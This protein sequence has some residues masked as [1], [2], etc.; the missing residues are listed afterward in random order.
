MELTTYSPDAEAE[1]SRVPVTGFRS[2]QIA[3]VAIGIA[4]IIGNGLTLYILSK[5]RKIASSVGGMLVVNQTVVDFWCS[6]VLV[7]T[8]SYKMHPLQLYQKGLHDLLCFFIHG[9][10]LFYSFVIAS[11]Y[12]LI[13]I[14]LERYLMVLHPNV[15]Q[16]SFTKSKAGILVILSWVLGSLHPIFAN[17]FS[18]FIDVNGRCRIQTWR[19]KVSREISAIVYIMHTYILPMLLF[20]FAYGRICWAL[21]RRKFQVVSIVKISHL[22]SVS[23]TVSHVDVIQP[24]RKLTRAQVNFTKTA[25]TIVLAFAAL[26][27]P[28]EIEVIRI[29]DFVISH[30]ASLFNAI[31]LHGRTVAFHFRS[32]CG[33]CNGS[34]DFLVL[35]FLFRCGKHLD[36]SSYFLHYF[37]RLNPL[38][39]NFAIRR[40]ARNSMIRIRLPGIWAFSRSSG[41]GKKSSNVP[42]FAAGNFGKK[43]LCVEDLTQH[44]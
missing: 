27:M 35:H 41:S 33:F 38:I 36:H 25:T 5:R 14:T 4:G 7:I 37:I 16:K 3:V 22:N 30:F 17:I 11:I 24:Q 9:E 29:H 18:T 13:L 21:V 10:V 12:N 43:F 15:H 20:T 32:F 26:W 31:L 8:H 39:L 44:G 40:D 2:Y 6:F 23:A 42:E 19:S 28:V 1:P 34:R